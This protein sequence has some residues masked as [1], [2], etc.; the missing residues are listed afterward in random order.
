MSAHMLYTSSQTHNPLAASN[1]S[2]GKKGDL[3]SVRH[4]LE[5]PG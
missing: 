5:I 2:A 4:S 1:A 3:H